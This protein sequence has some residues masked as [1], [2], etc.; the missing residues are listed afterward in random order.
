MPFLQYVTI[1]KVKSIAV[2]V[3]EYFQLE[4]KKMPFGTVKSPAMV[5]PYLKAGPRVK[6]TSTSRKH[7]SIISLITREGV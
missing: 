3:E 2:P 4:T 5:H 6:I 1:P 7:R